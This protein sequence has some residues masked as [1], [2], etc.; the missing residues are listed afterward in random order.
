MLKYP[1]K[2]IERLRQKK[3][4]NLHTIHNLKMNDKVVMDRDLLFLPESYYGYHYEKVVKRGLGHVPQLN[5]ISPYWSTSPVEYFLMSGGFVNTKTGIFFDAVHKRYFVDF[6][7][8][9][10][11]PRSLKK[12]KFRDQDV[13]SV[14]GQ[15]PVYCVSGS[16]YHGIIEDVPI[17]L[18]LKN[19]FPDLL[20]AVRLE[21]VWVIKLLIQLGF[22][23]SRLVYIDSEWLSAAQILCVTKSAF[24][25]FV[26]LGLILHLQSSVW[27][28][29][30]VSRSAGPSHVWVSRVRAKARSVSQELEICQ[31]L[32]DR[33]FKIV[34]L[35]EM[36]IEEQLNQF[37][38]AKVVSG[39]HGAGLLNI[40][41]CKFPITLIEVYTEGKINSCY[42][43]LA[44][45]LGYDYGNWQYN[46][47]TLAL[48]SELTSYQN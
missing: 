5:N 48:I 17:V 24:G 35:E 4:P 44:Y 42:S 19:I 47:D 15:A 3:K 32:K 14:E 20:I 2:I 1:A 28:R 41:F 13:E 10:G 36:S 18:L 9:W 26:N 7:W 16:G 40:I 30:L 33:G 21:N 25:E 29:A 34:V 23:E 11:K 12:V 38:D 43:S 31:K 22:D 46:G 39:F 27:A 37:F 8:G 6:S 45:M